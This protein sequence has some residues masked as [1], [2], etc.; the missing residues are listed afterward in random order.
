MGV[1]LALRVENRQLK[2][3]PQLP[4]YYCLEGTREDNLREELKIRVSIDVAAE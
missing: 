2:L 4:G 1:G 3:F